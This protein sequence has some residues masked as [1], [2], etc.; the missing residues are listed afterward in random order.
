MLK[1]ILVFIIFVLGISIYSLWSF[2]QRASSDIEVLFSKTAVKGTIITEDMLSDLPGPV[3]RWLT[4][5]GVLGREEIQTVYLKQTG[6]MKLNPGQNKWIKSEAEQSFHAIQPQFTWRVRTTMYGLPVVGRDDYSDGK[7]KMLIKLAGLLPVVNLSDQPKLNEST[8]QR[9]LGEIVWFPTA[10]LSPHITWEAVDENSARATMEYAGT[11]GTALFY[12]DD[13][14]EPIK[15]IIPRYRE[16]DDEEPTDWM[17]E[18]K[19]VEAVNGIRVPVKVEAS[20]LLEEGKFTWY[21]FEVQD[22]LYKP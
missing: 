18:I 20:W 11:R 10:A 1:Y 8:M 3:Q 4:Y 2:N 6:K 13:R 17:A 5:C 21:V 7:G 22:L 16:M 14:G 19:S 9:Y 15:V 12:F